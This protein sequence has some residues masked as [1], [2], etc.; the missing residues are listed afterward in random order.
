MKKF[1]AIL[2]L[3]KFMVITFLFIACGNAGT[4]SSKTADPKQSSTDDKQTV[5]TKITD[6]AYINLDS[7]VS[8]YDYY[9]DLRRELEQKATK[10]EAEF[11]SKANALEADVKKF[12]ESYE[13]MLLTRSEAEEQ[14]SRLQTRENDLREEY[15]KL[16]NQIMEEESVMNRK[17]IDAIQT[18]VQKYNVDKKY[19]LILNGATIIVGSPSMDI[20][21]EISRGLNQEYIA[22]K[23]K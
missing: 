2:W 6:I 11:N 15:P 18:Y 5:E 17:V 10:K 7:I 20:T 3:P 4:E 14:K 22:N 1:I 8:S 21:A 23:G 9:H 16:R 12:T 19:A 13:K